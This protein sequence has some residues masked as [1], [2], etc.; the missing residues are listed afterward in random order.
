M[1]VVVAPT[2]QDGELLSAAKLNQVTD[3]VNAIKGASM[4]PTAIFMQTGESKTYYCRRRY[5]YL[6][7]TYVS[8]GDSI[9]VRTYINGTQE[10]SDETLR[11]AGYTVTYDLDA[12]TTPPSVGAWYAILVTRTGDNYAYLLKEIRESS[13][14]SPTGTGSYTSPPTWTATEIVGATKLNTLRDSIASLAEV[15]DSPSCTWLRATDSQYYRLRRRQRYLNVN[16]VALNSPSVQMFVN[17]TLAVATDTT[18]YPNGT[19]K[20]IDLSA[21]SGGPAVGAFYDLEFRRNSGNVMIG[22]I[23]ETI[24]PSATYAP[25]WAEGDTLPNDTNVDKYASILNA[26][27]AIMGAVGWQFATIDAQVGQHPQWAF[28][29]T[30]RYLHYRRN[31]STSALLIDPA[32]VE[33]DISM[34]GTGDA[35]GTYDLDSIGWL[36]PGGLLLGYEF[37]AI[38]LD[39]EAG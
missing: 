31:G 7:V 38:W 10:G 13:S 26:A 17:G 15:T 8:S 11:P 4:A 33:D 28:Y 2:W 6:H 5:R 22:F 9:H 27:Y 14:S 12:V 30:K 37:D 29:K 3:I 34:S 36:T 39:D 35:F 21:V 19:T 25:T 16:Y 23:V 18:E 1:T 20:T 24:A 32:G